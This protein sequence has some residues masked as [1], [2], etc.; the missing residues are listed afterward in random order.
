M[1]LSQPDQTKW[2][3]LDTHSSWGREKINLSSPAALVSP[4]FFPGQ[5]ESTVMWSVLCLWNLLFIQFMITDPC[6]SWPWGHLA[7]L[8]AQSP[9]GML[10]RLLLGSCH[11]PSDAHAHRKCQLYHSLHKGEILC[12]G[13]EEISDVV[14]SHLAIFG[15]WTCVLI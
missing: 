8:W 11:P 7:W 3:I 12:K 14:A 1:A 2:E 4:P 5:R 13:K 9:Q 10:A 15:D 6:A